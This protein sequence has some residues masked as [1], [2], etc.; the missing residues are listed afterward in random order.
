MVAKGVVFFI[1]ERKN[2]ICYDSCLSIR[3]RRIRN[4]FHCYEISTKGSSDTP[5]IPLVGVG[6]VGSLDTSY[7]YFTFTTGDDTP[8]F[9]YRTYLIFRG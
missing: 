9:L 7:V 8:V 6:L 2:P 5:Y 4:G 3:T 1:L